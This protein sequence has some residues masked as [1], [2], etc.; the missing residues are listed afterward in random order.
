MSLDRKGQR[1][2]TGSHMLLSMLAFFGVIIAVNVTLAVVSRSS[3]TGLV[4]ENSYVASQNFNEKLVEGREQAALGWTPHLTIADGRIAFR[5]E[6]AHGRTI[7]ARGG[8]VTLR[9]PAYAAEDETVRLVAAPDGTL[10]AEHRVRDGLWIIDVSA[11]VGRELP[12]RH[13]E[14]I[15]VAGGRLQ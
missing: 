7:E 4:V 9:R 14:R 1:E 11:D 6:D 15:T 8:E 2:F 10:S 13:G 12:Y 3:W 5:V